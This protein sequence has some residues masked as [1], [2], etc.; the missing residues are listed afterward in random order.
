MPVAMRAL[1]GGL[2]VLSRVAPERTAMVAEHLFLTPRRHPRPAAERRLLGEARR[3]TLATR[4][5]ALAAWEWGT[6]GPRVLLV[7]GWEGRGAQLAALA[8]PLVLMGFRVVTFDA[9]GHGDS[10]GRRSSLLHFSDAIARAAEALGPLHAIV[11]HSMGG[12][13]ML[14]ASRNGP[15]ARRLVMV[16]PPVDLR[17]FTRVLSTTLGLSEDVRSRVHRRLGARF[18]VEIEELR[19]ERLASTMTGPLLVLHDEHDREVPI[20]CGEAVSRAWAGS[21]LVRTHGLGHQRILRDAEALDV[22]VRFVA[23]EG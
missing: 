7:H 22:I 17:D 20:A 9:P 6:E 14:W 8:A 3:L 16:A 12:A 10:P 11:T 4:N 15:L 2:G 5:G 18:G 19:A 13:A 21:E 1:K 23:R